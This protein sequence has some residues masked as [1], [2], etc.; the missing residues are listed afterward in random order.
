MDFYRA[1]E[2]DAHLFRYQQSISHNTALIASEDQKAVSVF[3]YEIKSLE[4]AEI[5]NFKIIESCKEN[6]VFKGF[7]DEIMY[8]NP[9][10][11]SLI[12]KEERDIIDP[13]A[14][15]S[16][17]FIKNSLWL[18]DTQTN[19]EAFKIDI[20]DIAPAQLTVDEEKFK[21]V[22]QW[23]EK[24]E[25]I[26]ICC[27]RIGD[28]I[29]SIDGHSRLVAAYNRGFGYVYAFFETDNSSFEFFRTCLG[30]CEEQGIFSIKD[31][32][33]RVV[34]PS[35]HERIWVNKCQTHLKQLEGNI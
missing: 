2:N 25:D 23:I 27:V 17:G 5:I 6:I 11:K 15:R 4:E 30:W 3:E 12:Y 7:I 8:W 33:E 16:S 9:Y 13:E 19:I 18:L 20:N 21:R 1:K 29:V 10:L 14:L 32:A 35:E 34:S 24:P 26:V 22:A 31:L 28:K